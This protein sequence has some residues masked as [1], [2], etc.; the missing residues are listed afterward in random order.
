[1]TLSSRP[2]PSGRALLPSALSLAAVLSLNACGGADAGTAES[3]GEPTEGGELNIGF[4]RDSTG[5]LASLD[6]F[7][8][9]WLEHRVALRNV[10]ESLTDQ[11]PETGEIV[12]WLAES[13]EVS[14]DEMEYTFHLREGVTFSNGESFDAEAVAGAFDYYRDYAE[15]NPAAFGRTY[16]SGYS[17][18]E[19][20]DDHS[21][22]LVLEEPNAAFLQATSTTNLA[23]MAPE[24][25]EADVSVRDGGEQIIGT[26]PF[27]LA[28][29]VQD[30]HLR[31]E[32]R[33]GYTSASP[34]VQNQGE[35]YLDSVLVEYIPEDSVRNGR[36]TSSDLDIAWPRD[37]FTEVDQQL[38]ESAGGTVNSRSLPGP[39]WNYY[40]NVQEGRVLADP[41]VREALQLSINR[42]QI[43]S[44]VYRE[45]YPAVSGIYNETT[46]FFL[47]LSDE[48]AMDQD[49]AAELLD[50]AGWELSDDGYRY[51]AEGERL[52][53]NRPADIENSIDVLVQDQLRQVGIDLDIEIVAPGE[54]ATRRTT[55]DYDLVQHYMSRADPSVLQTI[56]DDR[57]AD[58]ASAHSTFTEEQAGH[59]QELFD[60][61]LGELDPQ[62][63]EQ[64]YGELQEYLIDQ[65]STFPVVERVWE[66]AVAETVHDFSWSAEGF[67][68]LGDIWIE[69]HAQ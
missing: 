54:W 11:D 62:Q 2:S 44:T 53:L 16:I 28:E 19:V 43:A 27:T 30:D 9:Y 49:R 33:E 20:H 59:I 36:F 21:L 12:P 60:A 68:P 6:P 41:L 29:Y 48:L 17:H 5:S 32:R 18:V 35:A 42:E 39:A 66:A 38:L 57:Y 67:A 58:S 23:V 10:T 24:S 40:P 63:R 15:E 37:P 55:G 65:N 51:N 52:T 69:E 31:L 64:H 7:Q 4:L 46:P 8:V 34:S 45:D 61:G 22:T 3:S 25:Y 47:D 50:E 13:W 56:I 14:D 1:M 26:G